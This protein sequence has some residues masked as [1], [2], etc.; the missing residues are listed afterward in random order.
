MNDDI[1]GICRD[2]FEEGALVSHRDSV[3]DVVHAFHLR[4]ALPWFEIRGNCPTCTANMNLSRSF[5]M[6]RN[7]QIFSLRDNFYI[8]VHKL[9]NTLG[10]VWLINRV[11]A[12][13]DFVFD[14]IEVIGEIDKR[15]MLFLFI[16][17]TAIGTAAM[18][19]ALTSNAIAMS[20]MKGSLECLEGVSLGDL[21]TPFVALTLYEKVCFR[22]SGTFDY[23]GQ[24]ISSEMNKLIDLI[25]K[26]AFRSLKVSIGI[27]D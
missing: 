14:L 25:S 15:R 12:V 8:A 18:L 11:N 23:E 20:F 1:C 26:V 9:K 4:C 27:S 5:S 6:R 7:I 10:M 21:L 16:C 17:G 19:S 22:T 24:K 2:S 13:K 3:S